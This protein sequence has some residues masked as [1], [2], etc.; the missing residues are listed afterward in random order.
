MT[1]QLFKKCACGKI[2]TK[3]PESAKFYAQEDKQFAD[4]DGY[5]WDCECKSTLFITL[6]KLEERKAKAA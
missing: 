3:L 4:L 6:K 2:F 1:L 5:Y